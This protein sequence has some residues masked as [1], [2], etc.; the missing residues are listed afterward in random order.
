MC[1][2]GLKFKATP[3]SP[4]W[5]ITFS[6][7]PSVIMAAAQGLCYLALDRLSGFPKVCHMLLREIQCGVHKTREQRE[8]WPNR[9][10]DEIYY[11]ISL[12]NSSR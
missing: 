5:S 3:N 4:A 10:W 2:I 8:V 6:S 11:D 1:N 7:W 12:D 9:N